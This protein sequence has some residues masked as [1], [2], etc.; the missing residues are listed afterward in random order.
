[1]GTGLKGIIHGKSIEL[2]EEAGLPEGQDNAGL[3]APEMDL[4]N[5]SVALV[6]NLT[7]VTH[8]TQ[9]YANV[10]NLSLADWMVP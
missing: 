9:D 2:T 1:M 4:F 7:Q 8:N 5:A 10:P 6:T 3:P